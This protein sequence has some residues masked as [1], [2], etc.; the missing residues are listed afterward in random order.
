MPIIIK[1]SPFAA[2][3][4]AVSDDGEAIVREIQPEDLLDG[5]SQGL[6]PDELAVLH[7]A[8]VGAIED[9]ICK[10]PMM[11]SWRREEARKQARSGVQGDAMTLP[12]L[13]HDGGAE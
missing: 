4:D 8:P 10:I 7:N 12:D 6:T 9:A 11:M 13:S 1:R 3:W 5:M 2:E